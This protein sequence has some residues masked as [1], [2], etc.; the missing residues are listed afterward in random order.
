MNPNAEWVSAELTP[1]L[2]ATLPHLQIGSVLGGGGG[3]WVFAAYDTTKQTPVALKVS[4]DSL[5]AERTLP[6]GR[7]RLHKE[8]EILTAYP[9]PNMVAAL[10]F[11]ETET[12]SIL[13][14]E[15]VDRV[16][17]FRKCFDEPLP[18]PEVLGVLVAAA[19]VQHHLHEHG[20][21]HGDT[22]PENVLFDP[23]GRHRLIDLGQARPWPYPVGRRVPGTAWYLAPEAIVGG[24]VLLPSTDVYALSMMAYELLAGHMPYPPAG[25]DE[26]ILRQ[27]ISIAPIPL[28][29][30]APQL[31]RA[32]VELV[33]AGL[34][35]SA[36]D[37]PQSAQEFADR[38]VEIGASSCT[39]IVAKS[40]TNRP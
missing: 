25:G 34:A 33:M 38:L 6:G 30:V 28:A 26:G 8:A 7:G 40:A 21:L 14:L 5:A 19:R 11:H 17:V 22:K 31:P 36:A 3:G 12:M 23:A 24:G 13:V 20:F 16:S 35:K 32:L 39:S 2:S 15:H 18:L 1:T 10:G 29:F 27:Q 37:R 9:H 4:A